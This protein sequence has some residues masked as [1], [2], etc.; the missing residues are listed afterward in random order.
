MTKIV[1][2]K[3]LLT[4]VLS[5]LMLASIITGVF[6]SAAGSTV[7]TVAAAESANKAI[8]MYRLGLENPTTKNVAAQTNYPINSY[9]YF[10]QRNGSNLKWQVLN[11]NQANDGKT[12]GIFLLA[13]SVIEKTE[14]GN[15][16][17]D[18]TPY[19]GSK[20]QK[21]CTSFVTNNF[22]DAEK[23]VMLGVTK[24]DASNKR[25]ISE[26]GSRYSSYSWNVS[27]SLI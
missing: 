13:D 9:V 5:V 8:A 24:T 25:Y 20:A 7:N 26:M 17:D 22:S 1:K 12:S 2:S 27:S 19:Q 11:N 10:G 15:S 3:K 23:A 6:V 21:W 16:N 4:L 18:T 14:F